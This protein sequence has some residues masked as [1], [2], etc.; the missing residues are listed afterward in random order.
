MRFASPL[1]QRP[2][3]MVLAIAAT[4]CAAALVFYLQHGALTALQ[5][6]TRVILRQIS[7]LTAG[8]VALEVRRTLDGPVFDT[9][10]AV[11]HPEL[12]AGRLDLVA[13]QYAEALDLYP[14]VDRFLVWS[15][16][17]EAVAPGEALFYPRGV[18]SS[19]LTPR[20]LDLRPFVRDPAL[21][22]AIM[23]LA[24]RHKPSQQIYGAAEGIGPDRRY[25]V[26]LRLF[27]TDARREQYF[28]VLGFIIDPQMM[29]RRLFPALYE[30]SLRALLERRGGDVPLTLRVTDEHGALVFGEPA[31]RSTA[32]SVPLPTQFYPIDRIESRLATAV[33]SRPWRIEVG[34]PERGVL[35]RG[36]GYWPTVFSVLLMLVALGLTVQA[37]RRAADLTR[38]QADFISH[39]SHQLKTPLSL[40]SAATETVGMDRIRSPEKLG[41]YLAIIR[42]E[43]ARLSALVQRI[44]EFSR[45]QQPRG[46]ELETVDLGALV[47]ETVAAF[48]S[49]LSGRNFTFRV[50]ESGT[51]PSVRADPAAIEQALVNLLDNAVKYSGE[52]R[53]VTVRAGVTGGDAVIEV[54]DRGMGID[55]ADLRRI[56]E[57]FY[58]GR[59]GALHRDGFGLGLPIVQELV[60]AHRGRVEVESTVGQ[61]ST[62]RLVLPLVEPVRADAVA[63]ADVEQP[64]AVS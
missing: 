51:A 60:H 14:H 18:T 57:K 47:R 19:G 43:V 42:S 39:V 2:H 25:N 63:V 13:E 33:P 24:E 44:L 21:G 53:H 37:N 48:E 38:M 52:V 29:R 49:S 7:E 36:Q 64:R 54:V 34:A 9:L 16:Q 50:E 56:F 17:T 22:R 12:R 45:L 27:W 28:E 11:N 55:K 1:F 5:S 41:Q 61:G 8:D 59:G 3:P 40:L 20:G 35:A 10:T 58:R 23:Q 4:F 46:Y 62:F 26:F 31:A 6:Q 32:A 30:R 15:A